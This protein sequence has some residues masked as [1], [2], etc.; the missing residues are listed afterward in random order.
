MTQPSESS[1]GVPQTPKKTGLNLDQFFKPA[2]SLQT[3][4]G[5]L[6]LYH[7]RASDLDTLRKLPEG[8]PF[9]RIREFLPAVAS[10]SETKGFKDERLPLSTKE[11]SRLSN[12]EL[13][14]IAERYVEK[15]LHSSRPDNSP[16]RPKREEGELATV[17]LDRLLT[18]EA[19]VESQQLRELQDK[20]KMLASTN[21]IFDGVRA[22]TS[23]LG[24]TLNEYDQLIK[25][26]AL[27][28]P[29][30]QR[31]D[32]FNAINEHHDRQ[33]RERAEELEMV[34]LTGQ[35]TA[36][37]AQTLKDLAEA[38]TVLL[39]QMETRDKK[40]DEATHKQ[41]KI[42]VWAVAVSAVLAV[43]S[44]F[45]SGFS[46]FQDKDNNESGDLWQRELLETLREANLARAKAE[47]DIQAIRSN[48]AE[49][50]AQVKTARAPA[51]AAQQRSD[52]PTQ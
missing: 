50:Q 30:A 1:G 41:I 51:S 38:A 27:T 31:H 48:V 14:S 7:L 24:T 26:I 33:I 28:E 3:S 6:Y 44:L 19:A 21:S 46:Y 10:L 22:S 16:Q 42:A 12:N 20:M 35:M 5:T 15:M 47:K 36:Q 29:L 43:V 40:T 11:I 37:S 52:R 4:L 8:D 39:E 32:S 17:Y 25:R 45:V 13:N 23:T 18:D 49:L 2:T 34:R 9:A